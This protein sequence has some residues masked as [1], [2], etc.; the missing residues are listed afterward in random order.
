MD[1]EKLGVVATVAKDGSP[2]AV[3]MGVVPNPELEMIFD[4]VQG[5]RKYSTKKQSARGRGHGM[6]NGNYRA[7]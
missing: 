4:T 7:V 5:A 2:E 1:R 6:H 3:L